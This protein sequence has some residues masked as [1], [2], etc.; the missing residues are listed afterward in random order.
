M[1]LPLLPPKERLGR[2]FELTFDYL[3]YDE[4]FNDGSWFLVHGVV[5]HSYT[6]ERIWHAW[7]M[8]DSIVYDPT[9]DSLTPWLEYVYDTT[10]SLALCY[11]REEAKDLQLSPG[12]SCPC[13][14]C[15][16][17]RAAMTQKPG[18]DSLFQQAGTVPKETQS[19]QPPR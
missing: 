5:A 11:S 18:L 8:R 16:Q 19:G 1:K 3:Y 13:Q 9:F 6:G 12:H 15:Q 17:N 14:S 4:R 2:C 7:L 10:V